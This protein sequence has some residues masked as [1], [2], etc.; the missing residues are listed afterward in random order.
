[1]L[2]RLERSILLNK[3]SQ[4]TIDLEFVWIRGGVLRLAELVDVAGSDFK[5]L[6]ES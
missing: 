2:T 6:L 4:V 5:I 1:M 3:V